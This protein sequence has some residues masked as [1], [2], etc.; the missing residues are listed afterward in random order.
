MA[1]NSKSNFET[2][3]PS[4]R[5]RES[6]PIGFEQ[7]QPSAPSVLEAY[8]TAFRKRPSNF[9]EFTSIFAYIAADQRAD[10]STALTVWFRS[11]L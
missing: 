5:S 7:M 10:E 3:S 11:Q 6:A 2:S 4:E 8:R 1:L 9:E